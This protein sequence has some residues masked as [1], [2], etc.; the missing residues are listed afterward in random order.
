MLAKALAKIRIHLLK[1]AKWGLFLPRLRV[2]ITHLSALF[3]VGG[4]SF[5]YKLTIGTS[6]A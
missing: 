6:T 5:S 2:I 4:L 1:L 3:R